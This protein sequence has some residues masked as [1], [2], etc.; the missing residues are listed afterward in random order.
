MNV[1]LAL[2]IIVAPERILKLTFVVTTAV[3]FEI[4]KL[5]NTVAVE[6]SMDCATV[7]LN[8]TLIASL[9]AKVVKVPLFVRFPPIL[10]T[11]AMLLLAVCPAIVPHEFIETLPETFNVLSVLL[12]VR[13]IN[14][15]PVTLKLL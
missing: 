14:N 6:P 1:A 11:W 13:S 7:P 10:N 4:V 12:L 9:F 3:V 8:V 5:L 15:V 2:T